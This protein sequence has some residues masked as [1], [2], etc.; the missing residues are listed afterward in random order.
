MREW[1]RLK[2]SVSLGQG[3]RPNYLMRLDASPLPA[4]KRKGRQSD[5][6]SFKERMPQRHSK[7]AQ[8]ISLWRLQN[9]TGHVLI[10]QSV[11]LFWFWVGKAPSRFDAIHLNGLV[12]SAYQQEGE[13]AGP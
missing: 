2:A 5:P 3:Q 6:E 1:A 8:L 4:G 13:Y 7:N 9:A 12:A 10:L 11:R